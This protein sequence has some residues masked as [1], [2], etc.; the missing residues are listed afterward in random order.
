[1]DL[2]REKHLRTK[3]T[4]PF[5]VINKK[6]SS[7]GF[8]ALSSYIELI[9]FCHFHVSTEILYQKFYHQP[10]VA[11]SATGWHHIWNMMGNKMTFQLFTTI[12]FHIRSLDG[13]SIYLKLELPC[14][15]KSKKKSLSRYWFGE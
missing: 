12:Y 3:C 13:T 2:R 8:R 1:M 11:Y 15:K 10:G 5:H 9:R 7:T 4:L 14:C 6:T